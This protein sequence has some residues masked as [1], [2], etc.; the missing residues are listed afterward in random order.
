MA[1]YKKI[2]DGQRDSVLTTM[3]LNWCKSRSF[4]TSTI[5]GA[6]TL[7]QLKENIDAFEPTVK[8]SKETLKATTPIRSA[9][10]R[11]VH[12]DV[13]AEDAETP[14]CFIKKKNKISY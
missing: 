7:E 5:I 13:V 2:A 14:Y 11:S 3:A 4:P 10:P 8:L 6:T 12:R 1:Q 9:V